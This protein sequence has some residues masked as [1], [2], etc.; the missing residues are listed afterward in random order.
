MIKRLLLGCLFA[1]S[2]WS[3]WA[4]SPELAARI[5]AGESDDRV[6]A[7]QQALAAGDASLGPFL[8]ALQDGRVRIKGGQALV[9][10]EGA[11]APADAEE[12]MLN[13][14]MR[15][16][17]DAALAGLDL[18][19]TDRD[20]RAKALATLREDADASKLPLLEKAL[21]AESDAGLRGQLNSLVA[22]A[23][24]SSTDAAQRKAAAVELAGSADPAT[25]ALLLEK[26]AAETDA[27]TKS[28][29]QKAVNDIGDRL[30]WGE[31]AQLLFSGL[32]LGSVLLLVA[33]G[34]AITYGLMGVINMAHGEL[35]MVGAYATYM[36][37]QG[38]RAW[39]PGAFDY[40]LWVALP[41]SFLAAALVG[42][43]M[44]R[45]VIRWLY[46]RPLETLLAT[47]GI[48][49]VL[50]QAVRTLFGA[51][52][53]AVENP[54]WLSGGW[55]L[56]PNLTLPYNRLAILAFAAL[57]LVGMG[58]LLAKTRLGLMVRGV[59]QNRRMAAC[60]GVNTAKVDTM[61]FALGS[62]I[63]GLA[64]CALSQIGNVGPD[65]GQ[66]YIVD[67]FMVVV[68]GGVGQLAG[69]VY[70]GLGLGVLS[71][72][73][74]GWQGAVLAKIALL[75]VLVLVIQK[76][77]QGLFALKGRVLD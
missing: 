30:A 72:L 17:I 24:L 19:S 73:L 70:A 8:R 50:M 2:G 34:L 9:I 45:S 20:V 28:A 75:L 38:F 55:A 16:E 61:A 53:V 41:A 52:N 68:L 44:E 21:A 69:T 51:Q 33:L 71:K 58:A 54:A 42:A 3:A 18:L 43:A 48:S 12:P 57:V 10:A 1:L 23:K 65:L 14:R 64:G 66:S 74:E 11:E 37:Q 35:L 27:A 60:V 56:L 5:A 49:L 31:R 6:A 67:A 26:L 32:S 7:I 47:W 63:A 40:Y 39:A 36:V 25:R 29:M 4:L 13:N 76:K 77:P 15:R 22:G 62:G 59:T 46:G